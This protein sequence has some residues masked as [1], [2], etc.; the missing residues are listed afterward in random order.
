MPKTKN[1]YYYYFLALVIFAILGFSREFLFVNINDRLYQLYYGHEDS[2]LPNS[3]AFLKNYNYSTI[4][5]SKFGLTIV[6]FIAYMLVTFYAVKLITEDVLFSKWALY[7]FGIVLV[8]AGII[9]AYNYFINQQ[10]NGDEYTYSR[11]LM[12]IVQSPLV[13]FFMIASHKLYK[14]LNNK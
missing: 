1:L 13:A 14:N 12:G 2:L 3:L 10:L 5:Y 8:L 4:Y 11:W 6:Y 9:T 7:L